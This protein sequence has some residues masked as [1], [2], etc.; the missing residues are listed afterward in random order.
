MAICKACPKYRAPTR[1]C[2]V[3]G[4][5][6][7]IKSTMPNQYCP[8]GKWENGNKPNKNAASNRSNP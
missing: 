6:V 3:C 2:S 4:C 1:Q 8:E 7:D 5:F